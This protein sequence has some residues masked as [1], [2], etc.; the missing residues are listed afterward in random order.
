MDFSTA[1]AAIEHSKELARRFSH[2]HPLEERDLSIVVV[3]ESGCEVHREQVFPAVRE[4]EPAIAISKT[5]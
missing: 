1:A 4:P 2:E 5:G 3:D